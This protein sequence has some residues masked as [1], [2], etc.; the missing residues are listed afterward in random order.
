M[1]AAGG[2]HSGFHLTAGRHPGALIPLNIFRDN[3]FSLSNVGI[4]VIGFAVTAM[5]VPSC[6]TRGGVRV[7]A[8][9]G[10]TVDGADGATACWLR[11]SASSSTASTDAMS[12]S[13]SRCWRS[14]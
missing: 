2:V 9:P 3:D 11:S 6:S 12:G 13:A 1:I 8:D 5:V 14:R 4:A 7:D 10:R